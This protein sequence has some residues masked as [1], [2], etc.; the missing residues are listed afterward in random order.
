[1]ND[2]QPPAKPGWEPLPYK[3]LPRPNYFPAG[4]AMGTTFI[5]WG[6]ITSW[7][8]FLVGLGLFTAALAGWITEI[9]HER[10]ERK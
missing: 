8:I 2:E 4:L 9:L 10:N 5:F 7:V 6:F 3:H 1:M